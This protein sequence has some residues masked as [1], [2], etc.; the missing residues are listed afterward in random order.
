MK[1]ILDPVTIHKYAQIPNHEFCLALLDGDNRTL[2]TPFEC[3]DYL[4]DIFF[5]EYTGKEI[6]VYGLKWKQG[7]LNLDQPTFKLALFGGEELLEKHAKDL[8]TFLNF[9]DSSQKML[10]SKVFT[11]DDP[12]NIVVEFDKK[13]TSSGPLLSAYTTLI[14][15][16]G[17]YS[18]GD[19]VEYLKAMNKIREEKKK[20]KPE[21]SFVDVHRLGTT[22]RKLFAL[23]KGEVFDYP[24]SKIASGGIAHNTGI[25]GYADFPVADL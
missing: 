14:R 7:I 16:A 24:W 2:H 15:V 22:M 10:E 20:I 4:Q 13:W 23:L 9:F 8:E 17:A 18:G 21:Y 12:H 1:L 6:S 5:S 19:P 11:T 25:V 3:K